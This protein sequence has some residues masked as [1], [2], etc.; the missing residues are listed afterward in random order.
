MTTKDSIKTALQKMLDTGEFEKIIRYHQSVEKN[1]DLAG[2]AAE[3]YKALKLAAIEGISVSEM[4]IVPLIC[5][6][7]DP[8]IFKDML[9]VMI[10]ADEGTGQEI[11]REPEEDIQIE[12]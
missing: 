2:K 4:P 9:V 11:R 3:F 12:Q 10:G 5:A 7:E 1:D 8:E 6:C